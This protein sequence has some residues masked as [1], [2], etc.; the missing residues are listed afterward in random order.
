MRGTPRQASRSFDEVA[1]QLI[2]DFFAATLAR[3][4]WTHSAH[5]TVATW[6]TL[7]YEPAEALQRIRLGIQRLNAAHGVEQTPT[8]GY[9]ETL[10]R[11]YMI[12]VLEALGE[13]DISRPFDI[14]TATVIARCGDRSLPRRFY[15]ERTLFSWRARTSW[16]PPDLGEIALPAR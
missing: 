13:M 11:V 4:A 2:R 6:C 15:S 16:V 12:L 7:S 5:L 14:L 9:H 10:T 8:G 3:E 1:P